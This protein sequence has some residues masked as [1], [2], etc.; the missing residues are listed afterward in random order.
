LLAGRTP[1]VIGL[2]DADSWPRM[3]VEDIRSE[4]SG[5][6]VR[7]LGPVVRDQRAVP[8]SAETRLIRAG[9]A[10]M[11]AAADEAAAL[12]SDSH[13]ARAVLELRLR[14]HGFTDVV[15][16]TGRAPDRAALLEVTGEYRHTWIHVSRTQADRLPAWW[17]ALAAATS[18][19][20]GEARPG[21]NIEQLTEAASASL[22]V[23]G[24]R[25][26]AGTV[27][28]VRAVNQVDMATNGEIAPLTGDRLFVEGAAVV[29]GVELEVGDGGRSAMADTVLLTE[30]G[31]ENL[32]ATHDHQR[33]RELQP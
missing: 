17:H 3:L 15:I 33:L 18:A 28:G 4:A 21:V 9:S 6:E 7:P 27:M 19:A 23:H 20:I 22:A 1:G 5:W 25:V 12:G 16:Q 24:D 11:A 14:G 31:V 29:I 26:P 10:I 8:S 32:T 2:V 30:G 13:R